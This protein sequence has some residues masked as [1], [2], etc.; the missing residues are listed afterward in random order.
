MYKYNDTG[1]YSWASAP[2]CKW[3]FP[4]WE[5]FCKQNKGW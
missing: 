3:E 5:Q 1:F 4:T 2:S